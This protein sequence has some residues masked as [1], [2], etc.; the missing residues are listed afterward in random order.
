LAFRAGRI[1]ETTDADAVACCA[2]RMTGSL[3]R[4]HS[5]P[6]QACVSSPAATPVIACGTPVEQAQFTP[7]FPLEDALAAV[8]RAA[9]LPR[10]ARDRTRRPAAL[11][12]SDPRTSLET[13]HHPELIIITG[14][15]I[16]ACHKS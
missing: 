6:R 12:A 1:H 13:L 7:G 14:R 9:R 8:A 11:Y 3:R 4:S 5:L 2:A 16:P 10:T 15:V